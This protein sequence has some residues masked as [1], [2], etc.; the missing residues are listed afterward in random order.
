MKTPYPWTTLAHPTLQNYLRTPINCLLLT[1]T[2]REN[3]H[4]LAAELIRATHCTAPQGKPCGHCQHCHLNKQQNHPDSR[5]Y[6]EPLKIA[7]IRELI[8]KIQQS[9]AVSQYRL[10]YL[11]NIDRYNEHAINALLKTLEEPAPYNHFILSAS[12]RRA[13][14]ATILSR[15]QAFAV[16]LPNHEQSIDYLLSLG[17]ERQHASQLLTLYHDNPHQAQHYQ[18]QHN[19]LD[20]LPRLIQFCQHPIKHTAFL[21]HLESFLP[22]ATPNSQ[23]TLDLLALNLETLIH[24]K[25]LDSTTQNWHNFPLPEQDMAEIDLITL[26]TLYTAI[27]RLRR[28]NLRQIGLS[29]NLKNLLLTHTDTRNRAL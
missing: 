1:D 26:H 10:I 21:D 25:Q 5:Y 22:N 4:A 13:V 12:A 19:P 23:Q 15:A 7:D 3:A 24:C 17:W 9:P 6:E 16:P 18:Q 2:Q 27:C 11:G 20:I 8:Q 28:P 14:K 29:V